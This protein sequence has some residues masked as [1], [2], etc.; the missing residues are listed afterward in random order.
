MRTFIIYI[1]LIISLLLILPACSPDTPKH[2]GINRG[3][4][5][6]AEIEGYEEVATRAQRIDSEDKWR[7]KSFDAGDV[8]GFYSSKGNLNAEDGW[9]RNIPM[10]YSNNRFINDDINYS[11]DYFVAKSTFYYYPWQENVDYDPGHTNFLNDGYG[12]E[13]RELDERDNIVKC[14]DILW[15]INASNPTSAGFGHTSS[16]IVFIRGDGFKNAERR[17]IKVV[18]NKGV[19]HAVIEDNNDYLKNIRFIYLNG[20]RWDNEV[21]SEEDSK[22]WYAWEG[23]SFTNTSK[24]DNT[25][26]KGL[27]FENVQYV[28]LPSSRADSRLSVDHIEIFD[29]DGKRRVL[30]NFTLY[31]SNK[32]LY[33]GQRY[34]LVI[35]LEGLE[36]VV[37]TLGIQT[38]DDKQIKDERAAGIND[39]NDFRNWVLEYKKY[40]DESREKEGDL[41]NFG[42]KTVKTDNSTEWRFY[43]NFDLDYNA[44]LD[45]LNSIDGQ[46]DTNIFAKLEDCFDGS[47]HTITGLN[48]NFCGEIAAGGVVQNLNFKGL[49]IQ[50][51]NSEP[52]GGIF[53][54]FNGKLLNCN[55]DGVVSTNG[56][57]GLVAA[58]VGE[59]VVVQ[60]CSFS[61]L[62]IGSA[63]SQG[64]A[65]GMFGEY[66]SGCSSINNN[67]SSLIFQKK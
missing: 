32:N 57:V 50:N 31:G 12:I 3:Y 7:L 27:T 63:T 47:G 48:V 62:I 33:Y 60:D 58:S 1:Y 21:M 46:P 23:G 65:Y 56:P 9:F 11:S 29:D 22:V 4:S 39:I 30:S 51:D 45:Y 14:K 55:I 53:K 44:Y 38:W 15:V 19:T 40:I 41:S 13:L 61:G 36:A 49:N 16:S 35:K 52:I 6:Y 18:L 66:N 43:L 59:N 10:Y 34:P 28:M 17:E 24:E 2:D 5:F 54:T 64:D 26:Y 25:E 20:Y 37:T 42:D 67:L 8:A